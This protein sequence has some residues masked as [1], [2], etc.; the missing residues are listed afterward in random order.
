M[1]H[2]MDRTYL[3]L[4]DWNPWWQGKGVPADL[5]GKERA[6]P[7]RSELLSRKEIKTLIGIRRC[8]KSTLL[9]QVIDRLLQKG[10]DPSAILLVNFD[11]G[12]LRGKPLSKI[13]ELYKSRVNVKD[14][15]NLFLDEVHGC[16]DWVDYIRKSYDLKKL[17][18]VLVTDSSSR[19][20]KSEY[21]TLLTGRTIG[22][23]I[24]P[25]S[26]GEFCNWKGL[27]I[28]KPIGTDEKE[29][30]LNLLNEYSKWGGF[31][32]VVLAQ[33]DLQKKVLLKEYIDSI[34]YKDVVERYDANVH[35]VKVLVNYLN[36]T[37]STLFSPRRFSRDHDLSLETLNNYM[38]YL[39]EV[40]LLHLVPKFNRSPDSVI[41][42]TKKVYLEDMGIYENLALRFMEGYGKLYENLVYLEL[43]ARGMDV[44]YW[45]D[46]T[47]ECDFVAKKG[48][49]IKFVL[50]VCYVLNRENVEREVSGLRKASEAL[51]AKEGA[52]I[53]SDMTGID[54][55]GVQVIPL[56]E[57]L[58]RRDHLWK[59]YQ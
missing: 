24:H 25:L 40:N 17:G 47:A 23:D 36:S 16:P 54:T 56:W 6:D 3:S 12:S 59:R 58:L 53:S 26:F 49:D 21:S 48:N 52:I 44:Y 50:Q 13:M 32:E 57:F 28:T 55:D 4:V 27:D 14:K 1:D 22:I 19:S 10:T 8:G 34:V 2:E 46:G 15:V 18:Q 41:R 43:G 11:D 20:I 45:D 9:Y 31:P 7:V 35:K 30:I 42:S 5:I 39:Q 38:R 33:S 29:R 51:G 37:P